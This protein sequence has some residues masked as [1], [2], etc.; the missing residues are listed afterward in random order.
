VIDVALAWEEFVGRAEIFRQF[1]MPAA[2][3][4][5]N[6]NAFDDVPDLAVAFLVEVARQMLAEKV[7]GYGTLA[8]RPPKKAGRT[9]P[10]LTIS[11]CHCQYIRGQRPGD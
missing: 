6:E 5:V 2:V 8:G 11:T 3:L 10:S 4:M 7:R 9:R 1:L